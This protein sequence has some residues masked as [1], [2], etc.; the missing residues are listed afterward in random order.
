[1]PEIPVTQRPLHTILVEP[2]EV[3]SMGGPQTKSLQTPALP[4]D[5]CPNCHEANLDYDSLL[6]LA[7]P[8]CGYTL[9]GCFT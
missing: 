7:C 3:G 9:A 6:N 2:A 8:A 4:G 1:M 5:E